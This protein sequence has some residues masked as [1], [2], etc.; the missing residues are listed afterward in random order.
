MGARYRKERAVTRV[1]RVTSVVSGRAG[2]L[3][4]LR[5]LYALLRRRVAPASLRSVARA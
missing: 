4:G 1:N 3:A 5:H 2:T